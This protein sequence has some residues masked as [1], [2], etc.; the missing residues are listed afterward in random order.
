MTLYAD[1]YYETVG[2]Y[3]FSFGGSYAKKKNSFSI[4]ANR[5]FFDG[6]TPEE[7]DSTRWKQWKPKLQ[8]NVDG[9]YMYRSKKTIL[10]VTGTYF[11]EKL[12]DKGNPLEAFNYDKAFDK[13]HFTNRYVIRGEWIQTFSDNA[14]LN[15]MSA[16][17]FYSKIKN[18][19]LKDLTNLEEKLVLQDDAQDT[20]RF[21]NILLR[22]EYNHILKSDFFAY[23]IGI[24]FTR[25]T[26]DGKRIKDTSQVIGD[27]AAFLSMN[28]TPTAVLSIQ[29]GLR[30]IYNTNYKAPLVYSLNIKWNIIER[31]TLRVS[32][33]RGFRAPSL[34]ELYLNFDDV[35]HTIFGN[36]DLESESSR[37]YN[38]SLNYNH[39][40]AA[41]YNWGIELGMFYNHIS[42]KIELKQVNSA[43]QI[44]S[45]INVDDFYTQGFELMFNNRIYPRLKLN[46]GLAYTG[47]KQI[48][49]EIIGD[50]EFIYSTDF[51]TQ[52]NYWW[53]LP[54][55]NFSVFYKY[56]GA[57][58][59]LVVNS[60][61]ETEIVTMD[62]YN[63]LDVNMNRWFWKRRINLQLGAKN[64]FDNTNLNTNGSGNSGGAHSGGGSVPVNWG[65]TFFIKVQFKLINLK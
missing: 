18:T 64:L 45:Y 2:V 47:R 4:N 62:A 16:Y 5:Y 6:Y 14:R 56:N 37:N 57:Y 65:R 34:K 55:I 59:N 8:W 33:A 20:T 49:S 38:L 17:S 46:F 21:D 15:V 50:P 43:E 29:P 30:I 36:P 12:Q 32:A 52:L 24:D 58:P 35:N 9:T 11:Y 61:D 19:Y 48:D 27:Y 31:L 39:Q 53:K 23:Q 13:Y 42:N 3:D 44:Y 41:A 63:S 60:E 7:E 26:A 25:E 10:K 22:A 51:T 40:T 54:D 1:A 28:F